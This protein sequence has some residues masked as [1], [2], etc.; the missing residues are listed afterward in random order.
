MSDSVARDIMT[1]LCE[2][3]YGEV[4]KGLYDPQVQM[5]RSPLWGILVEQRTNAPEPDVLN[6]TDTLYVNIQVTGAGKGE[7]GKR[8]AYEGAMRI[9]RD[10][11]L[12]LDRVIDGTL[13]LKISPDT[14]PYEVDGA[15]GDKDYVL[16][17]EAVRYYGD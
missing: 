17:I 9:Y 4:G 13:Y 3:G 15:E 14:A 16:G 2:L 6:R 10:L 11:N 5:I 12:I 1:L 8:N 7:R